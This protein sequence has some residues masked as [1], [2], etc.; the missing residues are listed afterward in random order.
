MDPST[1]WVEAKWGLGTVANQRTMNNK[2][3][4]TKQTD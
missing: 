3:K 4:D 2:V 1:Q